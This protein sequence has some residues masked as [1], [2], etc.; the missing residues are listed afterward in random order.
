MER[1]KFHLLLKKQNPDKFLV[2]C[3]D[4]D[5]IWHAHQVHPLAYAKDT[6]ALLGKVLNHDDSVNDRS[7][8]SRLTTSHDETKALWEASG[9]SLSENGAM[10]RGIPPFPIGPSLPSD[11]Y[12][13]LASLDYDIELL[14]LE[15]ENLP[16]D[17]RFEVKLRVV[18][19][20]RIC[21]K[22]LRGPASKCE[23]A[24]GPISVFKFN[25]EEHNS[26][27]VR[28][29]SGG[30]CACLSG[31]PETSTIHF[32]EYL[33]TVPL[34]SATPDPSTHTVEFENEKRVRF[35][36]KPH[37]PTRGRYCF[38]VRP[39]RSFAEVQ[40]VAELLSCPT[41]FLPPGVLA[42]GRG[43]FSTSVH[44]IVDFRGRE[45]LSCRVTH[46]ATAMVSSVEILDLYG[47]IVGSAHMIGSDVL[48]RED[49]VKNKEAC[50]TLDPTQAG[51]R[52]LLIRG[53]KDWAVCVGKW[54]GM[55]KGV[56]GVRGVKGV[57]GSKGQKPVRGV[58]GTPGKPGQ[59]GHLE[60]K[61]FPL[62]DDHKRWRVLERRGFAYCYG[63]T[64]AALEIDLKG[65]RVVIPPGK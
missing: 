33:A 59:P 14:I 56:S 63:R 38:T 40:N 3:Y 13:G 64:G 22:T 18:N 19:G 4:F 15:V 65:G 25:T 34:G 30:F 26:I 24:S 8:G 31:A 12:N 23:E 52:A 17:K 47:V 55:V 60:V 48:P 6:R 58:K 46:S 35:V 20:R 45:A 1:Y 21:K 32:S 37:P 9:R 36:T 43:P 50:C 27:E 49:Q 39:Q 44:Q 28:L 53:Q 10:F 54:V 62:Y 11:R 29:G 51:E 5:L 61:Y 16:A 57:A 41:L 42:E 7:P 2:P